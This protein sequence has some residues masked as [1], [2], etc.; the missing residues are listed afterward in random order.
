MST[1]VRRSFIVPITTAMVAAALLQG[2]S[3]RAAAEAPQG[4]IAGSGSHLTEDGGR[5]SLSISAQLLGASTAG[6][7]E[8]EVV[9]TN[10]DGEVVTRLHGTVMCIRQSGNIADAGGPVDGR[11]NGVAFSGT[12]VVRVV[13]NQPDQFGVDRIPESCYEFGSVTYPVDRGNFVVQ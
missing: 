5:E 11:Y 8:F 3:L 7:G 9:G 2:S 13:D 10:A 4:W 6:R 12:W 1:L